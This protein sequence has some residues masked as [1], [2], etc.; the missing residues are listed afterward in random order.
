MRAFILV[1][2]VC[3][4]S[5]TS[6]GGVADAGGVGDAGSDGGSAVRGG[7]DPVPF[8]GS[9]PVLIYVPSGYQPAVPAP[10]VFLLHGFAASGALEEAYFGLTPAAEART[11]LYAHPDG[12]TNAG[13]LQFWNATDACCNFDGSTVDD[14][15]YLAG[16]VAEVGTRYSVDPKRVFFVGQDNGGFMAYR[17]ACDHAG[18]VAGVASFGG[19]MWE[20]TARC[21]PSAAV[22]AV[23][24][25]GTADAQ[26]AYAG[27]TIA[28]GGSFP[29][30]TV[31]AADWATFDGCATPSAAGAAV[32][33][34]AG[35]GGTDT[36]VA[37]YTG[38]QSGSEAD[39]WTMPDAGHLPDIGPGFATAVF[40]YL[41]A[42]PKP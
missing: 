38:C 40:D 32:R 17:M 2:L 35:D 25:H 7:M 39:L 1:V 4:C 30:A 27:G 13:G 21:S 28:D 6:S 15:A 3:A 12:T 36:A 24:I 9:R 34:E 11:V 41:L 42:H 14:S 19:A 29:A 10:L 31:T 33:L 20:N 22:T 18:I 26:I 16:L 37:R 23:E 5:T 8:G